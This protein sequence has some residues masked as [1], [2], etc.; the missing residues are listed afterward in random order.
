MSKLS[1]G[2]QRCTAFEIRSVD[3]TAGIHKNGRDCSVAILG[4]RMKGR[5]AT[6]IGAVWISAVGNEM[7]DCNKLSILSGSV[8][9]SPA[10]GLGE[11][12]V[13]PFLDQTERSAG[14]SSESS[15]VQ[16]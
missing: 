2:V 1:R 14:V 3:I 5:T 12:N 10:F 13:S 9:C 8:E 7:F 15:G 6:V 4:A 16:C 11:L